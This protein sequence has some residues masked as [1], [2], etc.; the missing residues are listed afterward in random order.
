MSGAA[1]EPILL[2]GASGFVGACVTRALLDSGR[3]PHVILRPQARP[4]RLETLEGRIQ[5]HHADLEDAAAIQAILRAVRPHTVLHL[6]THGAY[7]SQADVRAILRTNVLGTYNLLEASA[8]VG[9]RLFVNTGSSSEYGFKTAPMREED[10]LEPNSFYAVAKAAQSHL[11][12]FAAR[13]WPMALAVFRLFS[14]YG[15]WEEPT[16]LIPTL[17]RRARAGLPL[18]MS[19]PDVARDFVF[20]DDVVEALLDFPAVA[21]LQAPVINLG[22]GIQTSLGEVVTTLAN[23][24]GFQPEVHWGKFPA[25]HW[26]TACWSADITRARQLLGWAPRHTLRQGLA[27]TASWMLARSAADGLGS[28]AAAA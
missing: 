12:L 15:P 14:V 4:W 20:V 10:R 6:A 23:M 21:R 9:V 19:Q 11:C 28:S 27:K 26:D 5:V 24:L 3:R 17:I 8:E 22:T 16:R 13:R 18:E 1:F 25:R 7:E 2:T